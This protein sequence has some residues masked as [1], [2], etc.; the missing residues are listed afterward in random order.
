[1]K[2]FIR[3]FASQPVSF[4]AAHSIMLGIVLSAAEWEG[5]ITW[6]Y[7]ASI[8]MVVPIIAWVLLQRAGR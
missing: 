3:W 1:M 2:A 5:W 6:G 4:V 7:E 8:V